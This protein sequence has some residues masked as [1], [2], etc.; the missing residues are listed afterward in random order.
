MEGRGREAGAERLVS[1]MDPRPLGPRLPPP[2]PLR[3]LSSLRPTPPTQLHLHSY[4]RPQPPCLSDLTKRLFSTPP[5]PSEPTLSRRPPPSHLPPSPLSPRSHLS[6]PPLYLPNLSGSL[7][8]STP[9][10][11]PSASWW[12]RA[13][14]WAP[15]CPSRCTCTESGS[16]P[17]SRRGECLFREPSFF[18]YESRLP[19]TLLLREERRY[20]SVYLSLNFERKQVCPCQF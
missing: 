13:R 14:S 17:S 9:T 20:A 16:S 18:R 2:F 12:P 15:R 6:T 5:L 11:R 8:S 7:S 19:F 4:S 3:R 10:P 1:E